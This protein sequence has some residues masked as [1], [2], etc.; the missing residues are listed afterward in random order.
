MF[1]LNVALT[2]GTRR[3]IPEDAILQFLCRSTFST[4]PFNGLHFYVVTC[5]PTAFTVPRNLRRVWKLARR[6]GSS[7]MHSGLGRGGEERLPWSH[8][9]LPGRCLLLAGRTCRC[10]YCHHDEPVD[11]AAG[12]AWATEGSQVRVSVEVNKS[13]ACASPWPIAKLTGLSD[14]LAFTFAI[15]LFVT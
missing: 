14:N 1:L 15:N 7:E 13:C 2:R 3:N 9:T 12:H 5:D 4:S 11:I 10:C 6:L 8:C